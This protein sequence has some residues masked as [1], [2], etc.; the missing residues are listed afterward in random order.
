LSKS[1]ASL[2][3]SEAALAR[4]IRERCNPPV[5]LVSGAI[6]DHVLDADCLG[7][8]GDKA[9]NLLGLLGL[10][11]GRGPQRRLRGGGDSAGNSSSRWSPS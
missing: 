3:K 4:P 5:V 8:L 10:V 2:S 9:A 6:E 1:E 7:T 11:A